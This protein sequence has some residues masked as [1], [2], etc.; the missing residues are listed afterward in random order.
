M[1]LRRAR[2]QGNQ[3]HVTLLLASTERQHKERKLPKFDLP[4]FNGDTSKFTVYWDQFKCAVH[5]NKDLSAAQKF[6]YLRASLKGA[7]LQTID[8]FETTA[9][10]YKPA[11]DA[12]LYRFGRKKI[13]V[14]HLVKSIVK[15]EMKD[16][17][18]ALSLR[19][20]HDT[21]QNRIRALERLGLKP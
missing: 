19:Q 13:I 18:K 11:I 20:L 3:I 6:S 1:L 16:R 17:T 2:C 15:L 12:I 10:N 4:T 21:L 8:A 9:T 7:A 5:D 14:A